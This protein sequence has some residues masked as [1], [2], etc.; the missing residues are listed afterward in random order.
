[1]HNSFSK[2]KK[3]IIIFLAILLGGW[4]YLQNYRLRYC[5]DE[6]EVDSHSSL[7]G[8]GR[9]FSP[10]NLY[11]ACKQEPLYKFLFR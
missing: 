4:L 3:K 6:Y 8:S 9:L 5:K 1:M 2:N 7:A 10:E 11:R